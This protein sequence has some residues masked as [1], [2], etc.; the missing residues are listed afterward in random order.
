MEKIVWTEDYSVGVT[1]FD[2][3]HQ[4]I[5][6]LINKLIELVELPFDKQAY[7]SIM[8]DLVTYGFEH[9]KYEEDMLQQH[10]YPSFNQHKHEHILYIQKVKKAVKNKISIDERH[11]IDMSRFLNDWWIEHILEEDMKYRSFFANKGIN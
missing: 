2:E 10:G 11:L 3:Q 6:D 4:Q 8:S 5:I 9:L 7:H 1:R